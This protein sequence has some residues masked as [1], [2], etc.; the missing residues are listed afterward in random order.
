MFDLDIM[1]KSTSQKEIARL[2]VAFQRKAASL[3]KVISLVTEKSIGTIAEE[4]SEIVKIADQKVETANQKAARL[5]NELN[6]AL[7]ELAKAKAGREEIL[8]VQKDLKGMM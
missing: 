4:I 6:L 2:K 7:A 5:S 8:T 1:R 3:L